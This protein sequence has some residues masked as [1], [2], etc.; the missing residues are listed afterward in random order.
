M[1]SGAKIIRLHLRYAEAATESH[2]P[3]VLILLCVIHGA[4]GAHEPAVA[5][6]DAAC[7]AGR[8]WSDLWEQVCRSIHD[9][10]LLERIKRGVEQV[11]VEQ[12]SLRR[13]HR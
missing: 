4:L 11:R 8:Q 13:A 5:A 9:D 3:Q 12:A 6:L 10:V 2:L 1:V 7:S